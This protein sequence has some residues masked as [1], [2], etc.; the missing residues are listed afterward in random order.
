MLGT[1]TQ[2]D[3]Y[4]ITTVAEFRSMNDSTAYFKLMNDLDVNDSEWASGWTQATIS[5]AQVNFDGFELRNINYS[6]TGSALYFGADAHVYQ[7]KISNAVLIG[8]T[9][10]L[11]NSNDKVVKLTDGTVN[12]AFSGDISGTKGIL[13]GIAP[14]RLT[15]MAC[16]IQVT[17]DQFGRGLGG[18][19]SSTNP[20]TNII[21]THIN[22]DWHVTSETSGSIA[23]SWNNKGVCQNV[24]IS[25]K[26]SADENA[27]QSTFGLLNFGM[28]YTQA[29]CYCSAEFENISSVSF[30]NGYAPTGTCFYDSEKAG[31]VLTTQ[32]NVY[33]LT[34]AQCKDKDY[35]NSIGFVVV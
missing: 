17:S 32:E 27:T 1:G 34:T 26:F 23:G 4:Q 25:G 6:G 11:Y 9:A 12:V 24:R 19:G 10:S 18:T 22:L 8:N 14:L 28:S 16:N 5:C 2:L 20:P 15:N 30:N 33:A 21:N 13:S 7:P 29:Q 3:P 35:L 31:I